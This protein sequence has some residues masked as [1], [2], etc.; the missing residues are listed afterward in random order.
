MYRNI[1]FF[2]FNPCGQGVTREGVR[3]EVVIRDGVRRE[4]VIREGEATN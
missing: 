1:Y 3:R 2:V 4:G